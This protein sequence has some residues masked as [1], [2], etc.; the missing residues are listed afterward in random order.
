MPL[1]QP[2]WTLIVVLL[3]LFCIG[4]AWRQ[5]WFST[6]QSPLTTLPP[7]VAARLMGVGLIAFVLWYGGFGAIAKLPIKDWM[8][9]TQPQANVVAMILGNLAGLVLLILLTTFLELPIL[10]KRTPQPGR[11]DRFRW[12]FACLIMVVPIVIVAEQAGR[13][14]FDLLH[15]Q[16]P[17]SHELLTLVRDGDRFLISLIIFSAVVAAPVFEELFFRGI[18]QRAMLGLT[19]S[20]WGAIVLSSGV[21][22]LVHSWWLWPPIFVLSLALGLL[23]QRTASLLTVILAHAAFNALSLAITLLTQRHPV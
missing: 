13:L 18:V 4:I 15:L 17:P 10:C 11:I 6:R 1:N 19:N 22:M 23:Y 21:F 16:H 7:E 2:I 3:A 20:P 14:L 9:L 8:S 5:R 12:A